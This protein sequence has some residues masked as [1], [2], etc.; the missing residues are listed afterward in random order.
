MAVD[1]TEAQTTKLEMNTGTGS[2]KTITEISLAYP[3]LLTCTSHGLT[4]G[5]V[6]AA[7]DFAGDDAADI[8]GNNYVVMYA[9]DDT[10]AIDLDSTDLTITDNTDSATMTPQ[11]YTEIGNILDWDLPGDTHN[12]IDYTA[13]GSTRAEEK[14]GIPRGGAVTF[15]VNWT[16]DDTGLLAAETARAAKT[17]KTFKLTY[18]DAS[19]HTFTGYVIG[20]SDSGSVDDKV[21]GTITLQRTGALTLS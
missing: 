20:I 4:N 21:S 2:A 19:V 14:P 13:L 3:T 10:F 12:M 11:S 5:D 6:A 17:L 8:N 9:T 15:S 18:S 16:S 7:A 1:M